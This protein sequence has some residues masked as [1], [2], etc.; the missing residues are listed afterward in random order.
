MLN[1]II[2]FEVLLNIVLIV[3]VSCLSV[4]ITIQGQKLSRCRMLLAEK[5]TLD[6]WPESRH[7]HTLTGVS[8][9]AE[10]LAA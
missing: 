6:S 4:Y 3:L 7:T 8:K 9:A 5:R 2:H 10:R 1:T